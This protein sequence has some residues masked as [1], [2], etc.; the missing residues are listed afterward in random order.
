MAIIKVLDISTAHITKETH[1]KLEALDR[2]GAL[3][4]VP[5]YYGFFIYVSDD[6]ENDTPED[7]KA[8]FRFAKEHG[9]DWGC[10]S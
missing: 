10:T 1:D 2:D 4:V 5:H 9:C 3:Y 8:V 7:L 6:M